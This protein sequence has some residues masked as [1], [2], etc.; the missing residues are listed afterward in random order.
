MAMVV[1]LL[2]AGQEEVSLGPGAAARLAAEGITR[3]AIVRDRDTVAVVLEGW[4]FD[5]RRSADAVVDALAARGDCRRLTTVAEVSV[6][7]GER[8]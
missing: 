8:S 6:T 3:A 2:P 4:A 1:L 5:P 7:R